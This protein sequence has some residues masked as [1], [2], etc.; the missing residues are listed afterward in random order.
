MSL[1]L[2]TFQWIFWVIFWLKHVFWATAIMKL[3]LMQAHHI[4]L[5]LKILKYTK[6]DKH[7]GRSVSTYA[8]I[9]FPWLLT[10][11]RKHTVHTAHKPRT[12]CTYAHAPRCPGFLGLFI[13]VLLFPLFISTYVRRYPMF[14]SKEGKEN[15]YTFSFFFFFSFF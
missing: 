15:G 12:H 9:F 4:P 1:G 11:R 7:I 3:V 2:A 14:R 13:L 6:L 5:T 8:E 10:L